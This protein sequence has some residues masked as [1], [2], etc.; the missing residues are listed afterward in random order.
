[1]KI[2]VRCALVA[3]LLSIVAGSAAYSAGPGPW[4]NPSKPGVPPPE[5]AGPGA[6]LHQLGA[7]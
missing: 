5:S 2:L 7:G 1:M 3:L 4:G 6:R